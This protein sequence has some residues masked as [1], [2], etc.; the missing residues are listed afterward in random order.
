MQFSVIIGLYLSAMG[1]GGVAVGVLESGWLAVSLRWNGRR[2]ARRHVGALLF[3]SFAR[4]SYFHVV[5]FGLVFAIGVLVGL[6]L[7]LLMR[8]LKDQP[9]I[10][11]TWFRGF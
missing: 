5:L 11:R 7:P 9:R 3:F 4:L 6:E 2:R 1:V 10:S 8:L